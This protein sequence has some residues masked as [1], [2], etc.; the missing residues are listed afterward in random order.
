MIVG[1]KF[2]ESGKVYLFNAGHIALKK[3]DKV[4]VETE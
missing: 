2:Q 4:I 3:M 1:I